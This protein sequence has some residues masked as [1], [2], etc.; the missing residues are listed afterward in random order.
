M[1]DC[2]HQPNVQKGQMCV[3]AD[4]R[5]ARL[6]AMQAIMRHCVECAGRC[7]TDRSGQITCAK[8]EWDCPVM[9]LWHGVL[10]AEVTPDYV[11]DPRI[12]MIQ[13]GRLDVPVRFRRVAYR[14]TWS[15]RHV[16]VNDPLW[17]VVSAASTGEPDV[18]IAEP[19]LHAAEVA[20]TP[21]LG[22]AKPKGRRQ[23]K[24]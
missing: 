18:P 19:E 20:L 9:D 1:T 6:P 13:S 7:A 14:E 15:P 12:D 16:R 4:C 11:T 5:S 24:T 8:G 22:P 23:A 21:K 2:L 17:E 10:C 3:C